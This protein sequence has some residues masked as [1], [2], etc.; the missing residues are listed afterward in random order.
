MEQR[1]NEGGN[2][3][4]EDDNRKK[5]SLRK[6]AMRLRLDQKP[7]AKKRARTV[8]M[9]GITRTY[10]PQHQEKQNDIVRLQAQCKEKISG[11]LFMTFTFGCPYPKSTPKKRRKGQFVTKRPDIDNYVKYYADCLNGIAY[12]DDGQ[13]CCLLAEK[14]YSDDPYIEI[15][16]ISMEG[17]MVNEHAKTVVEEIT[18]EDLDYMVKKANKLG[19]ANR[20]IV[21]VFSEKDNEGE[22][23][24]FQVE[25]L[26]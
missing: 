23:I 4:E 13:I 8:R 11:P 5:S 2:S 21:R 19:L 26:K 14:R 3:P 9:K 20:Q 15:E 22:H 6:E 7:I 12:E 18:M 1:S 10:D 16:L 17:K 24:Y 25:E